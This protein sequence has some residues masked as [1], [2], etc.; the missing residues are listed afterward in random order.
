MCASN[1]GFS[2]QCRAQ[3]AQGRDRQP[4]S[5]SNS[6]FSQQCRA[7]PNKAKCAVKL[8]CQQF[9]VLSA[10]PGSRSGPKRSTIGPCQQFRVLSAMPGTT[11]HDVS[12]LH[13]HVPAIPGSL[14][15]AGWRRSATRSITRSCASNSGFSQQ[16]RAC[17]VSGTHGR[18]PC[19]QFRVLSAMPGAGFPT[20][21]LPGIYEGI[22]ERCH[23]GASLSPL[24]PISRWVTA[25]VT[26]LRVRAARGPRG[27]HATGAL[28]CLPAHTIC[29]RSLKETGIAPG[30]GQTLR[31]SDRGTFPGRRGPIDL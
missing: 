21:F 10:M 3:V 4:A 19:Q 14:S 16:C 2:Q 12:A 22:C 28:E 13:E 27:S 17:L 5:A 7:S 25:G 29:Q 24:Y 20:H 26:P 15:N 8:P 18:G 11:M 6:G 9:R 30:I 31:R 1:S 23:F